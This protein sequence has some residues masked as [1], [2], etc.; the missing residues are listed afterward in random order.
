MSDRAA[1][2]Q[3]YQPRE[4]MPLEGGL[5]DSYSF[6]ELGPGL[7]PDFP[8]GS[9]TYAAPASYGL[10]EKAAWQNPLFI[11][12]DYIGSNRLIS[13]AAA[14]NKKIAML[15]S[16]LNRSAT[17]NETIGN[18]SKVSGQHDIKPNSQAS[19]DTKGHF[20]TIV[21]N[22]LIDPGGKGIGG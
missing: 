2:I 12:N 3:S 21:G 11:V 7:F 13:A 10:G 1:P 15:H 4:S 20:Q 19:G 9:S 18:T 5:P 17:T 16:E 8:Y 6:G 22:P 14:Q